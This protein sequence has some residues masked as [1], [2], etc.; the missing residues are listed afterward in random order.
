MDDAEVPP[1]WIGEIPWER[2]KPSAIFHRLLLPLGKS[3]WIEGETLPLMP[4]PVFSS[5]TL[6]AKKIVAL[7]GVEFPAG[8]ELG[9]LPMDEGQ[10][11]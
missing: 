2:N 11:T 1:Y 6:H 10:E 7:E 3:A 8:F 4:P 5:V 9:W